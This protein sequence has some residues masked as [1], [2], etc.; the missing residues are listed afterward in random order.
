MDAVDQEMML[1][2]EMLF[3]ERPDLMHSAGMDRG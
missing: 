1:L 2:A 3:H